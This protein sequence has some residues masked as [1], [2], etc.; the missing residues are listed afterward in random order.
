[1]DDGVLGPRFYL[2]TYIAIYGVVLR[3]VSYNDK[4]PKNPASV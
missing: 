2:I 3:C 4:H 1:M